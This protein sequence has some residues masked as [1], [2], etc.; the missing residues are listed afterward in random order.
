ML[1]P[2]GSLEHCFWLLGHGT[3][4]HII[5]AVE[6]D[7]TAPPQAWRAAFDALRRRHPLLR[8]GIPATPNG[9]PYFEASEDRPIPV[10]FTNAARWTHD[11]IDPDWLDRELTRE[12]AE[13]ID[14]NH[15]PLMRAIVASDGGDEGASNR[16]LLIVAASH[17]I[18]DGIGLAGCIRDVLRALAGETLEP[19]PMPPSLNQIFNVAAARAPSHAVSLA[20]SPSPDAGAPVVHRLRLS[21]T[22]TGALRIRAR[23]ANTTV[24]GALSAALLLSG[25]QYLQ[26]WQGA[27]IKLVTPIDL[28]RQLGMED[29]C[30]VYVT[31]GRALIAASETL[32]FWEMARRV[33]R[34]TDVAGTRAAVRFETRDLRSQLNDGLD[35]TG[36]AKA[37]RIGQARDFI[38]SNLGP[39]RFGTRIGT[40]RM[41]AL[42]GPFVQ[43]GDKGDHMLGV[44]TLDGEMHLALTSATPAAAGWL[45][46]AKSTLERGL[47]ST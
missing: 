15:A 43:T 14:P 11:G 35:A 33:L 31:V 2:L 3:S 13:P 5:Y 45:E 12:L 27:V 4:N 44:A 22:L 20:A 9:F 28:R 21:R 42:W 26:D 29:D 30:G 24:H 34:E 23:A 16:S 10:H 32:S 47:Q 8:V 17:A 36:V 7:G 19:L 6:I 25:R 18:C 38:V 37:R 41:T 40:Y 46:A 1:R 39:L